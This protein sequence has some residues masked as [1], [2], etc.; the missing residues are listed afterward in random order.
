[1][2]VS[3]SVNPSI[4]LSLFFHIP[5]QF[6]LPPKLF[7]SLLSIPNL[8]LSQG[9]QVKIK[10]KLKNPTKTQIK[11]T[12]Q[13]TPPQDPTH[14]NQTMYMSRRRMSDGE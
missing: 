4:H 1:M 13:L 10:T 3:P 6:P 2:N 11:R 12:H 8:L 9:N 14:T 5:Q 7:S